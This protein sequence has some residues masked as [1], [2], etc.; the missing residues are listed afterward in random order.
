MEGTDQKPDRELE[1]WE[2]DEMTEEELEEFLDLHASD[3]S[4]TKESG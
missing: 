4:Y 3:G 1:D 2:I